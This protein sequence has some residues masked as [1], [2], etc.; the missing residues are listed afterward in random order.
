MIIHDTINHSLTTL[1]NFTANGVIGTAATTVDIITAYNIPQTTA[2][3][4][5]TLPNPT[6]TKAGTVVYVNN[7]GTAT[8]TMH[9]QVVATN[10]TVRFV[11][12]GT[13]W[14]T[15]VATTST[16][17]QTLLQANGTIK[18]SL[19]NQVIWSG[20][21]ITMTKGTDTQQP[22]G[23]HD[24]VMPTTGNILVQGGTARTIT[25]ALA[26]QSGQTGG[27]LLNV[28]EALWYKMPENTGSASVLTN[29]LI[30]PYTAANTQILTD[31]WVLICHRDDTTK[32]KWF[33]GD[34]TEPGTQFGGSLANTIQN[35]TATK[36][37]VN[38]DGYYFSPAG[39]STTPLAFGF[40]GGI[41]WIN[42]GSST[43]IN[44][45]GYVDVTQTVKVAGTIVYGVGGA[46]QRAWRLMTATEKPEW[47]GGATVGSSPILAA[48]TTVVDLNDN[49][50]LFY[51]PSIDNTGVNTGTWYVSGYTSPSIPSHWLPVVSK[52][53]SYSNNTMQILLG[54]VQ[55]SLKAG[56]AKYM[57]SDINAIQMLHHAHNV[58]ISGERYTRL[59]TNPFFA[60]TGANGIFNGAT[61]GVM[62]SWD[63]NGIIYGISEGYSSWGNQYTLLTVPAAGTQIQIANSGTTATRTVQ[64]IGSHRYIP[65]APWEALWFIPSAFIGG[66]SSTA[67]NFII[68]N[69]ATNH[70]VLAGAVCVAKLEHN[71]GMV[72]TGNQ[73]VRVRWADGQY[74]QAGI[75]YAVTGNVVEYDHAQGNGDW[76]NIIVAGQ[77]PRGATAALQ[78]VPGVLGAYAAPYTPQYIYITD[79]VE[80]K[81]TIRLAG[82]IQMDGF[83]NRANRNIGFIQGLD[84][85][86]NPIV[87][88][89]AIGGT[90]GDDKP[91][92]V[93]LRFTNGVVGS[94]NG[95]LISVTQTN[96]S[97]TAPNW[98]GSGV[99]Q[100]ISLDNIILNHS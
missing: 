54:G 75:S 49:E 16:P 95:I 71:Y 10:S 42:G 68:T 69:Y 90:N 28:W 31:E 23:Y 81:G 44:N 2:N 93:Q 15:N 45:L 3:I 35:W 30:A 38:C 94:Q 89:M 36:Q 63:D 97:N 84:V 48:S 50:T 91:I 66:N 46:A 100:W 73:K 33:N 20:R 99:P 56:D 40:T 96:M 64:T 92:M 65:L 43:H 25:A 47:F 57:G 58:S 21:L 87:S 76:R 88:A 98:S 1:A 17:L 82:L 83:I 32:V 5:L 22:A 26:G 13:A 85:R 70:Y 55:T 29:F 52:Q 14:I 59:T 37:R 72:G 4:V 7:T 34:T 86:G 53:V 9:G 61:V 8:F 6:D 80:P 62:I 24:V 41:R 74:T 11:W 77:T 79:P 39:L 51:V 19:S 18:H 78:A 27:I 67:A 60:G 12:T